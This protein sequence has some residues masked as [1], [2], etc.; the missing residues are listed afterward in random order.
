MSVSNAMTT[1]TTI[2]TA[3]DS[4]TSSFA[5]DVSR[6]SIQFGLTYAAL[7]GLPVIERR[8]SERLSASSKL[9]EALHCLWS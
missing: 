4:T 9:S 1:T 8:H 6:E 5:D 3:P 7:L 2:H